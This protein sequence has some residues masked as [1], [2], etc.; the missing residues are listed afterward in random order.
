[1]SIFLIIG[2]FLW[3]VG[4]GYMFGKLIYQERSFF[5]IIIDMFLSLILFPLGL[6]LLIL[7][8][9]MKFSR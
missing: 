8:I 2:I 3:I 1:M 7:D 6:L 4:S 5:F 9:K